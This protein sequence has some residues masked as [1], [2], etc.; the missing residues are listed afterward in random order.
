MGVI[1]LKS[2]PVEGNFY[3]PSLGFQT[4]LRLVPGNKKAFGSARGF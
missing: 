2:L 1:Q 3:F 4:S